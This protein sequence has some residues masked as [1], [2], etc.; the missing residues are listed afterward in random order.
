MVW[1]HVATDPGVHVFDRSGRSRSPGTRTGDHHAVKAGQGAADL[2][3]VFVDERRHLQIIPRNLPAREA[4]KGLN[5][6]EPEPC[7]VP[8]PPVRI[9]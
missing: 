2:V 1:D 4:R 3:G 6:P 7:L 8:A 9:Y 5:A